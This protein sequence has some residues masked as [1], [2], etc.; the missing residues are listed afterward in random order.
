MGFFVIQNLKLDINACS[1]L[2]RT[3]FNFAYTFS[4]DIK[5]LLR[6]KYVNCGRNIIEQYLIIWPLKEN[7]FGD[8][9]YMMKIYLQ[10]I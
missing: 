4:V 9:V 5:L 1:L 6:M 3:S 2:W 10:R 8:V 7:R